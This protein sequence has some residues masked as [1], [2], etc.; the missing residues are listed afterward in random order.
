M[1][2]YYLNG[3][4]RGGVQQLYGIKT[5]IMKSNVENDIYLSCKGL[6]GDECADIKNHGG[7]ERALHQYPF[8]HYLYWSQKYNRKIEW[9]APG[10][11]ENI[12]SVGMT[13]DIVCIGDRYGWGEAVIE[14]SQPR[15]PC[16]KLNKRW[17]VENL[18]VHMQKVSRCGWL[19]RVIV[20]GLVSVSKPLVLMERVNNA[21]TIRKVCDLYFGSPLDK[22]SLQLLSTQERLSES[23]LTK[24]KLRQE[25]GKLENWNYRLLGHA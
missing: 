16:F 9:R 11:G 24:V 15:S 17:G 1:K 20:P 7:F 22:S 19:Y 6:E 14:V 12:S 21:L 8:E 5:A 23:W 2:K 25:T 3:V 10:M 4:F 18:S 13:E